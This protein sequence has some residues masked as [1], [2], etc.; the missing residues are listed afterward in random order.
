MS[1]YPFT[2]AAAIAGWATLAPYSPAL[3]SA[4]ALL[5]YSQLATAAAAYCEWLAYEGIAPGSRVAVYRSRSI[6]T[7]CVM[8]GIDWHGSSYI[9]FDSQNPPNRVKAA[10]SSKLPDIVLTDSSTQSKQSTLAGSTAL[11]TLSPPELSS[12]VDRHRPTLDPFSV[13][14]LHVSY[15]MHTSGST[16]APK[17]V[18]VPAEG[19]ANMIAQQREVFDIKTTD[20]V[21]Q[22][23]SLSF[24]A[25]IF[26]ICLAFGSGATLL[27][28]ESNFS[29][30]SSAFH[31][32]TVAVLTPSLIR[33]LPRSS[34]LNLRLLIS[35]GE[36]IYYSDLRSLP[37][38]LQVVNA[39]GPAEG[40]IWVT[41]HKVTDGTDGPVPIGEPID[42]MVCHLE[43]SPCAETSSPGELVITGVGVALGYEGVQ[44]GNSA[45]FEIRDG[46]RTF[47]TGDI[48]RLADSGV[49]Y[50]VGR[51]D[52]QVK[53][54]GQ[55]V[56]LDEIEYVIRQA[57]GVSDVAV[58]AP[59]N[60]R[61]E[62]R[63]RASV[64]LHP[65]AELAVVKSAAA[66][67]LPT[68]W[69]PSRW[70]T[71]D[72]APLTSSGKLDRTRL[73]DRYRL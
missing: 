1:P 25:S 5:N 41:F 47:H 50:Y 9:P 35:A 57:P 17:G 65:D 24:D 68:S 49:L 70:V 62:V 11:R 34:L 64:Q 60:S 27:V 19:L 26:E 66:A 6:E 42:G 33:R 55:R 21:L 2:T 37:T 18:A 30:L 44:P 46:R 13:A 23:S 20:T 22:A 48:A 29:G 31:E 38:R 10:L 58:D 54:S 53:V 72:D 8:A 15:V 43:A 61:G 71:V 63:L 56:E 32:S 28:P 69:L 59:V 52:R 39:Y 67:L 12:L 16:G 51:A 40:T 36:Q 4:D 7:I 3:K 14:P 45:R 73:A